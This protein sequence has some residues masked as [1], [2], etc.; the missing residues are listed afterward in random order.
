MTGLFNEKKLLAKAA[1]L[2]ALLSILLF[3]LVLLATGLL[4]DEMTCLLGRA[5]G[6]ECRKISLFTS[7]ERF[8]DAK[9]NAKAVHALTDVRRGDILIAMSTHTFGWRHG[10]CGIVIGNEPYDTVEAALWGKPSSKTRMEHWQ[11]YGE[12]THLRVKEDVA[13]QALSSLGV[14]HTEG[15][16]AAAQLGEMAAAFAVEYG[17][18]VVYSPFVGLREKEPEKEAFS[19]TQCAHLIWYVYR[20]CGLDLDSDGGR[21]VTPEDILNCDLLER[22]S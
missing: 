14:A 3:S 6:S 16:S 4:A 17:I 9:G 18:D 2:R 1:R 21:I 8:Y 12:L 15:L 22:I 19:A 5:P 7:E 11:S 13:A 20:Q 10:H